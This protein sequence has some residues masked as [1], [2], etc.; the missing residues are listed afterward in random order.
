MT[1]QRFAAPLSTAPGAWLAQLR[2]AGN[3]K[4]ETVLRI[5]ALLAG[6]PVAPARPIGACPPHPWLTAEAAADILDTLRPTA[7]ILY[8]I[9]CDTADRGAVCPTNFELADL[10]G[11]SCISTLNRATRNLA[12]AGLIRIRTM[13]GNGRIVTIATTGHRTATPPP[14]APDAP[15]RRY[16]RGSNAPIIAA[17]PL[18][19]RVDRQPCPRCG[20]RGDIG[21]THGRAGVNW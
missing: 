21:C 5:Q 8:R 17:Q 2:R 6:E 9:L 13:P 7:R 1:V 18:P 20:T 14:P 11:V 4:P 10:A 12:D 19:P 16:L 15:P 3:P